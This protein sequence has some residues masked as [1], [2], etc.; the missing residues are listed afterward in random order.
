MTGNAVTR[1][2]FALAV[3]A[4]PL[5]LSGCGVLGRRLPTYRYRLT[6]EVRT[7]E[8]LRSGSS[9]IEVQTMVGGWFRL[10]D[11]NALE[12]RT[13]GEA[14]VVDLGRRG[15]IFALLGNDT[16]FDWAG[17]AMN[18]VTPSP[19]HVDGQDPYSEWHAAILKN[20]GLKVLPPPRPGSR[21]S[22]PHPSAGQ[23]AP[24]AYPTFVRFRRLSDPKTVEIVDVEHMSAAFGPGVTLN[25]ITLELTED[26]VSQGITKYI[27]WISE[28]QGSIARGD[29]PPYKQTEFPLYERIAKAYF[30]KEGA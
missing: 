24:I 6:V 26:P 12:I 21:E 1:R 25:R 23:G 3:A 19:P 14:V 8:G 9:V 2:A 13:W 4:A 15:V 29:V 10:P 16:Y 17:G 18:L 30:V 22:G 27:P 5:A 20:R 28:V 11:A 7:P